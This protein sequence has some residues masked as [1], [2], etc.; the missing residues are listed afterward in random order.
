MD[1]DHH[2]IHLNYADPHVDRSR[3]CAATPCVAIGIALFLVSMVFGII[4]ISGAFAVGPAGL[5]LFL[6]PLVSLLIAGARITLLVVVSSKSLLAHGQKRLRL[7]YRTSLIAG[8]MIDAAVIVWVW[9]VLP[10]LLIDWLMS[11]PPY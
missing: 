1:A 4:V 6:A 5:G 9:I 3:P 2:P 7:T 8:F 10:I 11:S